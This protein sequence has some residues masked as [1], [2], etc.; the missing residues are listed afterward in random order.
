MRLSRIRQTFFS[1][2]LLG[3]SYCI[4]SCFPQANN[5]PLGEGR[6]VVAKH[7]TSC[8]AADKFIHQQ[9]SKA[10]WDKVIIWMQKMQ[11]MP[12]PSTRDKETII[13][14]LTT[15]AGQ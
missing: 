8:H 5:L 12:T 2:H 3:T 7:C 10:G 13:E 1:I 4:S 14:Y 11:G 6:D 15:H 9:K